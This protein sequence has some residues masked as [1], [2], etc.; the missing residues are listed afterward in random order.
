MDTALRG[1]FREAATDGS[2]DV[3]GAELTNVMRRLGTDL[4]S[5]SAFSVFRQLQ[6]PA[7]TAADTSEGTRVTSKYLL[8]NGKHSNTLARRR[9]GL[10]ERSARACHCGNSR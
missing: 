7:H 3:T 5:R 4:S 10:Y 1:I 9:G 6:S 2:G 8:T